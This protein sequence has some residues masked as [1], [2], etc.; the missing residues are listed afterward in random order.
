MRVDGVA[1]EDMERFQA[2]NIAATANSDKLLPDSEAS[3]FEF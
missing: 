2:G 3:Q 1:D